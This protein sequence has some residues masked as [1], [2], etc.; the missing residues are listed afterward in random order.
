MKKNNLYD[1]CNVVGGTDVGCKRKA[2][3]D[4]YDQFQCDNGWVSVVCDG[5]GGHVGGAVASHLAVDTIRQFLKDKYFED[6]RRAIIEACDAANAAILNRTLQQ[7]E[8]T[9]MGSTCVM[10]IVRNGKVYMGS[11]GDSRIY[12]IRSKRITQLTKDQSYVQ[13]LIDEGLITKEQAEHHPRKNEI[14]NALGIPSMKPATVLEKPI[15]PEAGDSFLLCSDGLS[16]MLSDSEIM[17]VVSNQSSMT[18]E[19]RV[20]ELI[21]RA[22]NNGGLD[23]IT[24]LIVEFGITP[25]S[26]IG[27]NNRTKR[28]LVHYILPCL[29]IVLLLGVGGYALWKYFKGNNGPIE[30]IEVV[31]SDSKKTIRN[32]GTIDP[33]KTKII[34]DRHKDLGGAYDGAYIKF[35]DKDNN[36]ISIT[37]KC[38]NIEKDS[39]FITPFNYFSLNEKDNQLHII[40]S[41]DKKPIDVGYIQIHFANWDTIYRI[42]LKYDEYSDE[43]MENIPDSNKIQGIAKKVMPKIDSSESVIPVVRV[44]G[45]GEKH[46][47]LKMGTGKSNKDTIYSGRTYAFKS[48]KD[49]TSWYSYEC[50]DGIVCKIVVQNDRVPKKE[51]EIKIPLNNGIGEFIISVRKP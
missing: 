25:T 12:L 49:S 24:C 17:K 28:I 8:L 51:A 39:I 23:N 27:E 41:S 32:I 20:N 10:L 9:G 18:Q 37:L 5:M 30:N 22:R 15:E 45:N 33:N 7:P 13:I 35:T 31:K 6:P 1:Y 16:G 34:I 42:Q 11:V 40:I 38:K 46:I 29:A 43:E 3:E 48:C 4:W 2:N 44:K 36:S 19:K 47:L 26:V 21:Q 50:N 14:T